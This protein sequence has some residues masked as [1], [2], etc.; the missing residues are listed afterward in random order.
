MPYEISDNT[1]RLSLG[2]DGVFYSNGE[3]IEGEDG[4]SIKQ[5]GDIL[6]KEVVER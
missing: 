1:D 4:F 3:V 2:R 6:C 5:T